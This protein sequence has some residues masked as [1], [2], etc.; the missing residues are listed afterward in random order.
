MNIAEILKN[1]PSDAKLYSTVFGDVRLIG[2]TDDDYIMVMIAHGEKVMFYKDGY[3][4]SNGECV[5]FPFKENRVW[6]PFIKDYDK[7]EY[8]PFDKVLVGYYDDSDDGCF[9]WVPQIVSAKRKNGSYI[10]MNGSSYNANDILTYD[11]FK[12][13]IGK[14]L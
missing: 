3:Y 13:K 9:Y 2:V 12:Y 11:V 10:M 8:K 1:V 7:I 6:S 5:L 14:S 4:Y